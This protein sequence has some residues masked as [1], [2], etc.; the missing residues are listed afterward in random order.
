MK[1][2]ERDG[3]DAF[4][5]RKLAAELGCEAMSIYHHFP[6]KQHLMDALIDRVLSTMPAV[7]SDLPPIERL[8]QL[9]FDARDMALRFPRFYP[10]LAVHRLNTPGGIQWIGGILDIVRELGGDLETTARIFRAVGYYI[11]G[12]SLDETSG[13]AKG[14][15]AADPVPDAVIVRDYPVLAAINLYFKREH[16]ETTFAFGLDILLA[17]VERLVRAGNAARTSEGTG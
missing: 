1:V 5:V 12:A 13:Y 2:I 10:H 3:L 14:P 8:R 11:T 16:H 7:P 15:S 6:S 9:C 4:S 17:G